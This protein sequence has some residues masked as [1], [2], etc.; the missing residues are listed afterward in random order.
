MNGS[1][2]EVLTD[3]VGR[4]RFHEASSGGCR[5]GVII[6]GSVTQGPRER[7]DVPSGDTVTRDFRFATPT[8]L[9]PAIAK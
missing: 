7:F 6:E 1:V 3:R 2:V 4:F 8:R 9:T 5:L